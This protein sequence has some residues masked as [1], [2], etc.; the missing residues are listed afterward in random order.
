MV[1]SFTSEFFGSRLLSATV[2]LLSVTGCAAADALSNAVAALRRGDLSSAEK[3]LR[4]ELK[5]H[6]GNADAL[7][8]LGIVL[9]N[10]KQFA[11]AERVYRRA[12]EL[13][14]HSPALLNNY[15]NHLL[16]ERHL[17]GAKAVFL[18]LLAMNP[19]HRNAN[20]QMARIAIEQKHASKA[21]E[22]LDHI[23][24]SE[25]SGRDVALLRIEALYLSGRAGPA[26]TLVNELTPAAH[27]D[28]RLAS[29]LGL[30]LVDSHQYARAGAFFREA[31]AAAPRTSE[32]VQVA[33]EVGSKLLEAGAYKNAEDFLGPAASVS[34][35]CK[36]Q[37]ELAI[38][39]SH[40]QNPQAGLAKLDN[41]P[42]SQRTGDYYLARAEMLDAAGQFEQAAAALNNGFRAEP[43]RVDLYRQAVMFLVKNDRVRQAVSVVEAG[44]R[45]LPEEKEMLLL[46]A[47]TLELA[48][49][50]D[51]AERLLDNIQRRWPEWPNAWLTKG[52]ILETYKK[53]D[54]ARQMVEKA[55]AL[56]ARSSEAYFYL[57]ESLLYTSPERIDAA[58]K[59]IREAVALAPED[60][61]I[62][63]LAGR[64]AFAKKDYG[65]AVQ[66]LQEAIRLRPNLVQAHYVLAQTYK[67]LGKA[68][69]SSAELEQV[70]QIHQKTPNDEA[71]MSDVKRALFQVR[72]LEF[73]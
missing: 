27:N 61:W 68:Q 58:Q 12:L 57:A 25:R 32:Y 48:G 54:E 34:A 21:V 6:P 36:V 28:A 22:Y 8:L 35:C 18:K 51:E 62:R 29:S 53:Y 40:A 33:S 73:Q 2:L 20:L 63:A 26:D 38:A 1:S 50:T 49:K 42:E 44:A 65:A 31:I 41:I 72:P 10:E 15:G 55:V 7:G 70:S 47:T 59:N 52:I 5:A 3:T 30:A 4:A 69:Q 60:P 16:N 11:E 23:P 66:E 46:K 39:T 67:A 24:E 45:M 71:D 43:K 17:G 14:A 56:G 19:A 37:T 64:I 9:D 13:N